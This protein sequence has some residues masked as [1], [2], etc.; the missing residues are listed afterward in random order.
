MMIDE[1]LIERCY[2]Y[3]VLLSPIEIGFLHALL[4]EYIENEENK[5]KGIDIAHVINGKM[6]HIIEQIRSEG[7]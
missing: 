3:E 7:R 1:L 4:N 2:K 6:N 5:D